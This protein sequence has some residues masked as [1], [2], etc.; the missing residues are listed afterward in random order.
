MLLSE[1]RAAFEGATVA[2]KNIALRRAYDEI[3][4]LQETLDEERE[5]NY[6]APQVRDLL[7]RAASIAFNGVEEEGHPGSLD[8]RPETLRKAIISLC[9]MTD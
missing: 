9:L 7:E 1:L 3:E 4:W 2:E 8:R 6:T 5:R